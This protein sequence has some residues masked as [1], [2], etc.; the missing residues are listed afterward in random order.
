MFWP[1]GALIKPSVELTNRVS[2]RIRIFLSPRAVPVAD[3]LT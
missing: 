1:R 3:R 2:F